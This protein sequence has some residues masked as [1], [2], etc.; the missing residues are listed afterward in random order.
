MDRLKE[1]DLFVLFIE[2]KQFRK[3]K[4]IQNILKGKKTVANLYA[5]KKYNLLNFIGLY[6][7]IDQ[8]KPNRSLFDSNNGEMK[9]NQ[10]GMTVKKEFEKM[11]N[12]RAI[13]NNSYYD[14]YE[15][16][17]RFLLILQIMSEFYHHN[18]LYLPIENQNYRRFYVKQWFHNLNDKHEA[19]VEL[20]NKL[21]SFLESLLPI[22]AEIFSQTFVGYN[23]HGK[24]IFQISEENGISNRLV[25]L[26][27]FN[28]CCQMIDFFHDSTTYSV[29]VNDVSKS[30][31]NKN[32]LKT[33]T[34]LEKNYSIKQIMDKMKSKKST[35]QEHILELAIYD[36]L[37]E[38]IV[39][40]FLNID[41]YQQLKKD[42]DKIYNLN[43]SDLDLNCSFFE[44]RLCQ[45]LDLKR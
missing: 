2:D 38:K 39:T 18:N 28:V 34:F 24:T 13:V 31:V 25:Q 9:L 40:R 44:F 33:L 22:E 17:R 14:I 10:R 45:I 15:F 6:K 41:L 16:K 7:N 8:I 30:I 11:L 35:I 26:I 12:F 32:A 19:A 4:T 21:T 27:E 3:E 43:F 36:L 20:K 23:N 29:I 37:N 1:S 5:A 42:N